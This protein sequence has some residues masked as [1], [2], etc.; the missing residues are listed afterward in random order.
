MN[1][2]IILEQGYKPIIISLVITITL[3]LFISSFFGNI[4]LFITLFIAFIYRNPSRHIFRNSQSVLAPIDSTIEAIDIVDGKQKIYCKVNLCNTHTL[5]A[6]SDGELK[7]KKY[8]HGL[9][10]NPNTPKASLLNEQMVL[11]I[12]NL[13]IKLIS[14]ICNSNINYLENKKVYQGEEIGLFLDGIVTIYVNSE[15][16]LLVNIGDKLTSGQTILF[17]KPNKI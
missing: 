12:N 10:L 14:G 8:Q 4:A 17:R 13:K 11:K 3:W 7:I 5:R 16:Q 1:K 9:N 6:P 2:N 15:Y